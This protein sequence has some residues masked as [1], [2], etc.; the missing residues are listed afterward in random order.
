MLLSNRVESA[1]GVFD[2]FLERSHH[3]PCICI[4]L[5]ILI[6]SKLLLSL[7]KGELNKM[8]TFSEVSKIFLDKETEIFYIE[9]D[10]QLH[11]F[12]PIW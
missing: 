2:L 4:A 9:T 1:S 3:V 8:S 5:R 11:L 10:S 7:Q 12:K 6:R